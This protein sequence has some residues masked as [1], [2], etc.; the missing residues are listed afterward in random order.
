MAKRRPKGE[1]TIHQRAD[2]RYVGQIDLGRTA[3]GRRDRRT[4]YGDTQGAVAT[5][6]RALLIARDRNLP[7]LD[8][9][10]TVGAYLAWW[11]DEHAS[12]RL[13]PR[14]RESYAQV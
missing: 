11:I 8:P 10:I 3:D 12:K 9:R 7:I 5:E 1:G 6:L 14:T 4:V 13:R 2:G